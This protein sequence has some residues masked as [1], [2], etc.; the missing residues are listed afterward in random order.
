METTRTNPTAPS[1]RPRHKGGQPGNQNARKHG[2]YSRYMSVQVEDEIVGMSNRDL[3]D[4][5]A[6][7]RV[8]LAN[9]LDEYA[10]AAEVRDTERMLRWDASILQHIDRIASLKARMLEAGETESV[11]WTSLMD[12][13]RAANDQQKVTR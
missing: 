10:R 11:V 6:L 13:L 7:V 2:I 8:R 5:L 4:E 9:A 12:A 1:N 3:E